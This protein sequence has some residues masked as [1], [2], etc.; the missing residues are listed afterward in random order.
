MVQYKDATQTTIRGNTRD[1][2]TRSYS[3]R[4]TGTVPGD[5]VPVEEGT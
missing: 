1:I 4:R 5:S 3:T 2:A